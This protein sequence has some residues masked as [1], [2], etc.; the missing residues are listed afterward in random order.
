MPLDRFALV[1][2]LVTAGPAF[3]A[4]QTALD[5]SADDGARIE[6]LG[7]TGRRIDGTHM[8]LWHPPSLPAATADALVARLD[9]AVAALRRRVGRHGWQAVPVERIT[10]YLS[11]DAFV[12]HASGRAAVFVPIARVLDGRAP[13]LHEAAHELLASSAVDTPA[14]D[15]ALRVRRPLWL[16]EGVPDYI[17]QVVAGEVGI[18]EVGPFA[19]GGLAG[20]DAVCAERARSTDGA[21]MLPFV[22]GPGRPDVLF[23][24][25]RGRFA[26]TF[27]TCALSFTRF[28]ADRAGLDALVGLFG[29]PPSQTSSRLDN[30]AGRPLA[31]HR[32]AWLDVLGLP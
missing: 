25:D 13:Y 28:L 30:L 29:V 5:W 11:D 8:V 2:A 4:A 26:P 16:T 3:A 24:T 31:A 23:T 20:A 15:G 19:S 32:R 9:P 12:S 18:V 27:Y 14:T 17:A 21:S 6:A 10:F 7:K 22:G 1:L